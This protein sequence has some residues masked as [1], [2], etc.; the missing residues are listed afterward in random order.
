MMPLVVTFFCEQLMRVAV[1]AEDA[2]VA[3]CGQ[4]KYTSSLV[5]FPVNCRR[6][7]ISAR[8]MD[9]KPGKSL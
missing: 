3:S 5:V 8:F 7:N 4:I 2:T 6:L 9:G 1:D